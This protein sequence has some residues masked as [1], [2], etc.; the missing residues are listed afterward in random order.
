MAGAAERT[1]ID[2]RCRPFFDWKCFHHQ[3]MMEKMMSNDEPVPINRLHRCRGR[4]AD[5]RFCGGCGLATISW[6]CSTRISRFPDGHCQI[7]SACCSE[8]TSFTVGLNDVYLDAIYCEMCML[9]LK[10]DTLCRPLP[11]QTNLE[12]VAV[13]YCILP[14][15]FVRELIRIISDYDGYQPD[16]VPTKRCIVCQSVDCE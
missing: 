12:W 5:R 10:T 16:S 8:P 6:G 11:F 4:V 13:L 15:T 2:L 14:R 7:M 9:K 3:T 1:I